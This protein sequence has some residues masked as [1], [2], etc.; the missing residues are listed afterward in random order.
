MKENKPSSWFLS[1][2][3]G[4]GTYQEA[5]FDDDAEK[6][7]EYYRNKGYVTRAGRPAAS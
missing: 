2:I 3:T 4:R 7:H 5:K 1:F 6:V